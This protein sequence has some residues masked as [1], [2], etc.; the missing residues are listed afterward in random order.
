M[1]KNC[2]LR[3]VLSLFSDKLFVLLMFVLVMLASTV[4]GVWPPPLSVIV[5]LPPRDLQER[6]STLRVGRGEEAK[7]AKE[8]CKNGARVV[9]KLLFSGL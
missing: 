2:N 3:V 8:R 4:G 1:F 7:E 9:K 6:G 5:T